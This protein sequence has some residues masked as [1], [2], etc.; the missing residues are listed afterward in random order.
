MFIMDII[1]Y[2]AFGALN[3]V[4]LYLIT[5]IYKRKTGIDLFPGKISNDKLET[6]LN[7]L[8]YFICGPFGTVL[9]FM[10]G[11]FLTVMWFKYY[12]KK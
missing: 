10:L 7:L 11:I 4:L 6:V 1:L 5:N 3:I 8:A 9:V 2:F 12:R